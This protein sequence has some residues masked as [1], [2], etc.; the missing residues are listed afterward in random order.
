MGGTVLLEDAKIGAMVNVKN[1][2]GAEV[3]VKGGTWKWQHVSNA[4]GGKVTI[5][6]DANV[7]IGGAGTHNA[8]TIH[9][10]KGKV[11]AKV[12][13]TTGTI[14]IE[15]GVKGTL[16]LCKNSGTIT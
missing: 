1:K 8:G 5:D 3:T 7:D 9:V 15:A 6:A 4:K 12:K 11:T 13:E 2:A 14:T 10:K 16:V